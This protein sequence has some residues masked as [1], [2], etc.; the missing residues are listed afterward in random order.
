MQEYTFKYIPPKYKG[1]KIDN[2]GNLVP[3]EEVNWRTPGESW[4][5]DTQK[6][7]IIVYAFPNDEI[8]TYHTAWKAIQ[9]YGWQSA[10]NPHGIFLP[11]EQARK[12]AEVYDYLHEQWCANRATE[13]IVS[14]PKTGQ[15][16]TERKPL[17]LLLR[18]SSQ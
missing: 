3:T 8:T 4:G 6:H 14:L 1:N 12:V 16:A 5:V 15:Q 11:Q 10:Q 13:N 17:E 7:L 2:A 18:A 9:Q